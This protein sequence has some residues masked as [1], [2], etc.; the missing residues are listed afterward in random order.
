MRIHTLANFPYF[1][2]EILET[3]Q[4]P[5]QLSSGP[6]LGHKYKLYNSI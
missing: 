2:Q 4:Q 1:V 5:K 6:P 3:Q